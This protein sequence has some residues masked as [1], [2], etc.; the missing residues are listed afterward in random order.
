MYYN[1]RNPSVCLCVCMYVCMYVCLFVCL[2][3]LLVYVCLF[4][5][6]FVCVCVCVCVFVCLFVCVCECVC[7]CVCVCVFYIASQYNINIIIQVFPEG[8]LH[9]VNSIQYMLTMVSSSGCCVFRLA[10]V[11]PPCWGMRHTRIGPSMKVRVASQWKTVAI[12][13]KDATY[14]VLY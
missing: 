1:R 10:T 9:T 14:R 11:L 4:V 13:H 12:E 3:C 5:C 7:L 8:N 6:V 2:C